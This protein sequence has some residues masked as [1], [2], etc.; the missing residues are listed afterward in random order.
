MASFAQLRLKSYPT[1]GKPT[2]VI[3]ERK[4]HD[5]SPTRQS[6]RL[7]SS[8]AVIKFTGFVILDRCVF[9]GRNKQQC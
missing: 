9:S 3:D 6:A 5:V 4:V 1:T 7:A 8:K 2:Q